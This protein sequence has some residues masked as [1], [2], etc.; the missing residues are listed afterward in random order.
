MTSAFKGG[1]SIRRPVYP[2]LLRHGFATWSLRGG[3]GTLQLMQIMGHTSPD[4]ITNVY[5]HLAPQDSYD[6]TLKLLRGAED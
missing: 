6:A 5:R 2:H 4:M 3:M 1:T